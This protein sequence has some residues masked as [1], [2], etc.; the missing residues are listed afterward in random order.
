MHQQKRTYILDRRGARLLVRVHHSGHL[1]V[2]FLVLLHLPLPLLDLTLALILI[3]TMT[4]ILHRR[5]AGSR[6]DIGGTRGGARAL[7]LRSG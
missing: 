5:R 4:A 7:R 3:L 1:L 6:P 2:H